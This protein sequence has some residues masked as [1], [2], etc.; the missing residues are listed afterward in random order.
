QRRVSCA[1]GFPSSCPGRNWTSISGS[2]KAH[3]H[4]DPTYTLQQVVG[5]GRQFLRRYPER[6]PRDTHR[7]H[8]L[9]LRIQQRN[10]NTAKALLEFLVIDRISAPPSLFD[11]SPQG[12]G[13]CNGTVSELLE[14]RPA[15]DFV[16]PILRKESEHSFPYGRAV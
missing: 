2:R 15:D 12:F 14:A 3:V 10:G 9:A 13:R 4:R 1:G 16:D 5:D 6:R 7:R 11:L 8:R